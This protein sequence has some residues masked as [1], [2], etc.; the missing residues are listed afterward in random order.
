VQVWTFRRRVKSKYLQGSNRDSTYNPLSSSITTITCDNA[1]FLL[2]GVHISNVVTLGLKDHYL[3][4]DVGGF[5]Q[6]LSG[7]RNKI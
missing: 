2:R 3:D 6:S 1:V 7:H 5:L 4:G